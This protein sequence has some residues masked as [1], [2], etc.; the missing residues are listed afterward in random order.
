MLFI[1]DG[2][3]IEVEDEDDLKLT[4]QDLMLTDIYTAEIRKE[5]LCYQMMELC[6]YH[7]INTLLCFLRNIFIFK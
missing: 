4:L 1:V 7:K 3:V 6:F 2:E 5:L